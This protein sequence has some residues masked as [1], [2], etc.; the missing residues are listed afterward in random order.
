MTANQTERVSDE[1]L[2]QMIWKLER[3]GMTPKQLSLMRELRE[4]RRAKGEP[5]AYADPQAFINF[6]AGGARREWMWRNPGEDLMP[7]YTVPPAP[8]VPDLKELEAILDWILMLPCPTP[9]ATHFAMRLAVVIEACRAAML[10]S[11]GTLTNEDTMQLPGNSEQLEPVSNRDELPATQ[12]KPVAD[13]Y[14]ITSPT[15]SETSFTFDANEAA[16]F[17][18]GGWSV[19]EYVELERYQEAMIGNSPATPDGWIPVSERM[20]PEG[21]PM[22]VCSGNGVVQRT[23]YSFDGENWLDWYEQ[24]DLVKTEP[25]DLWQPLPESPRQE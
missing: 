16:N 1:E 12:F 7:L 25:D 9:K 21:T 19:Q 20:P 24:Y 8:V 17:I 23:V 15:G 13:L 14:G 22:L 5:V 6:K 18:N 10:Q 11:D 4:V 2:D 3:D